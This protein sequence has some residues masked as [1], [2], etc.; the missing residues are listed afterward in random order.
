M[1]RIFLKQEKR[2]FL[3]PSTKNT[4]S[5]RHYDEDGNFLIKENPITKVGVFEY[6]GAQID[7]DPENP[8]GLNPNKIY[9]VYRPAEELEKE[10]TINSFR[11]KPLIDEHAMLGSE[12]E[13]KTPAEK[14]GVHGVIG[15]QVRF[16][17]KSGFLI[18]NLKIYAG[19]LPDKIDYEG[20]KEISAGYLCKFI[21]EKGNFDGENYDFV[22]RD[23]RG[24]HIALVQ[25]GRSGPDVSVRDDLK[26][27]FDAKEL[28]KMNEEEKK[29]KDE[30]EKDIYQKKEEVKDDL[31]EEIEEKI[32]EKEEEEKEE[33]KEIKDADCNRVKSITDEKLIARLVKKAIADEAEKNKEKAELAKKLSVHIGAFDEKLSTLKTVQDVAKYGLSKLH[34]NC[35]PGEE[36]AFLKGYL[37]GKQFDA[38]VMF[39]QD[40]KSYGNDSCIREFLKGN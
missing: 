40:S 28:L 31:E 36:I 27:T 4:G 11:L 13:G 6:S 12:E 14:K 35:K 32:E 17:P 10:E 20:K 34:K 24:N 29:I 21:S 22:Q 16:D 19:S 23:I 30:E 1:K 37:E 8:M 18:G 2:I 3:M 5:E 39:S 33:E 25:E 26:F 38:P 15:D 7:S 9:K